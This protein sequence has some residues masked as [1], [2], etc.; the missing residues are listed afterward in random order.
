MEKGTEACLYI[1]NNVHGLKRHAS[2]L[3]VNGYGPQSKYFFDIMPN[4]SKTE[5]NLIL[6]AF[7]FYGG[8]CICGHPKIEER[9]YTIHSLTLGLD[10][11]NSRLVV[12]AM[13]IYLGVD[14]S[15]VRCMEQLWG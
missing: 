7:H 9:D 11:E 3:Y 10:S 13:A 12:E 2:K 14:L 5:K 1:L 8:G 6:M 4:I 15:C